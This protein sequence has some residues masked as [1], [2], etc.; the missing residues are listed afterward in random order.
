MKVGGDVAAHPPRA[1]ASEGGGR[2][3]R[4][5]RASSSSSSGGVAAL[6]RA[7]TAADDGERPGPAAAAAAAATGEGATFRGKREQ[8]YHRM[9]EDGPRYDDENIIAAG[10]IIITCLRRSEEAR[11]DG[12]RRGSTKT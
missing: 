1:Q 3:P 12:E 7:R 2:P 6:A 10:H 8:E 4:S 9:K 11:G 5:R